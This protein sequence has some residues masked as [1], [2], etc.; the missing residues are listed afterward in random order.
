MYKIVNINLVI[1]TLPTSQEDKNKTIKECLKFLQDNDFVKLLTYEDAKPDE[2]MTTQLGSAC[3]ASSLSPDD[4][5]AVYKELE[6]A[7]KCFVL[8]SELHIVYQVCIINCFL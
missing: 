1:D 2:Y 4:G 6:K 5:I 3:L 8:E 7:R